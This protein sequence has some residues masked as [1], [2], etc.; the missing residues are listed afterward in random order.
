MWNNIKRFAGDRIKDLENVADSV[1]NEIEY[2][3]GQVRD[4][5]AV[6]A[7]DNAMEAGIVPATAGMFGRYLSGTEVPLTK[8]P[9]DVRKAEQS[10]V[11][12]LVDL[13]QAKANDPMHQ[14]RV[15]INSLIERQNNNG[16]DMRFHNMGHGD[17]T[18]EQIS[19]HQT[20]QSEL[21]KLN[22]QFPMM[23]RKFASTA[24]AGFETQ[25]TQFDPNNYNTARY[26]GRGHGGTRRGTK[27]I[28]GTSN[29]LGQYSVSNGVLSDRY[30]FDTN[31]GFTTADKPMYDR[32][33][34]QI[35]DAGKFTHGGAFERSSFVQNLA[36]QAG[37]VSQNLG[38]IK[39]GSG[40][41][42]EFDLGKR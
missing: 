19:T 22:K 34:N 1:G 25:L 12:S 35:P 42:I 40:Y 29:T 23:D 3:A 4:K 17:Y 38:L 16:V 31:N 2:A 9:A 37:R 15:K 10:K 27:F 41:D 14:A 33:G 30:D 18:P 7:L 39:P 13:N 20:I 8:M 36:T 5:V 21:D 11:D 28:D 26:K 6:P 24:N 32:S